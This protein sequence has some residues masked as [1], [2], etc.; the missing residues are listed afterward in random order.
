MNM[1]AA[2]NTSL[3]H[4]TSGARAQRPRET[5]LLPAPTTWPFMLAAGTV[6]ILA[7]LVTNAAIGLLGLVLFVTAAVGWFRQ[8]LPHEKH[9]EMDLVV[10]PSTIRTER[11]RVARIQ[12]NET[13]RAQLPLQTYPISSGLKGG[14]AGGIAM[15]LPAEIYGLLKF[16][17]L[18]YTINLLGGAG[19]RGAPP[20]ESQLAAFH[21][22]WFVTA[23]CIHAVA[24]VLVGLLYGA[25]LPALPRHPIVLGGVIAPLLWTGLLHSILGIVNQFFDQRISWPWFAASQ[26]LFGIVA[27]LTVYRFGKMRRLAQLPLAARLGVQTPGIIPSRSEQDDPGEKH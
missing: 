25:L 10:A 15:I 2:S 5:V 16:H 9:E 20:S 6:L 7:S 17:S 13:H 19:T 22:S 8:I 12:L 23:L 3:P 27:G 18:W 14:I 4:E 1:N 26:F 21:L 24:S 11:R